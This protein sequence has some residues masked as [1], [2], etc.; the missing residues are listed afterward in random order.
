LIIAPLLKL[1]KNNKFYED[2]P[3]PKLDLGEMKPLTFNSGALRNI[4]NPSMNS[5]LS[6]GMDF[7]DIEKQLSYHVVRKMDSGVAAFSLKGLQN[8]MVMTKE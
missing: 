2:A 5:D 3:S 6:G 4:N 1:P 8:L 7:K